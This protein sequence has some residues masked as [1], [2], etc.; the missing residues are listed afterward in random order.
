[1]SELHGGTKLLDA[2]ELLAK[3]GVSEGMRIADLGVGGV[4]YFVLPAAE[5]VGPQGVVYAVDVQKSVLN[6]LE[7]TRRQKGLHNIE[8]VWSNLEIIGATNIPEGSIDR[9]LLINVL[10]QNTA[11]RN[12]LTEAARL[13]ASKGRLLVVDWKQTKVPFGPPLKLRVPPEE[14]EALGMAVGL[15]LGARF[16]AGRAHYG[17]IFEK[18]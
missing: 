3:L 16:D 7:S 5:M 12:V 15:K 1:M 6:S 13:L 18:L 10:F 8:L 9:G 14:I 17:L 11:R 2:E 4:G